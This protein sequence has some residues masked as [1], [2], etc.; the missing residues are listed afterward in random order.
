MQGNKVL[1]DDQSLPSITID[2]APDVPQSIPN[3]SSPVEADAG[4]PLRGSACCL[5]IVGL[6]AVR[7]HDVAQTAGTTSPPLRVDTLRCS[8]REQCLISI[9]ARDTKASVPLQMLHLP[10]TSLHAC[11]PRLFGGHRHASANCKCWVLHVRGY[12]YFR[13]G[14]ID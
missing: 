14:L 2:R 8:I 12:C 13:L 11:T 6:R 5:I 9:G 10:I 1:K 3:D 4:G 7:I